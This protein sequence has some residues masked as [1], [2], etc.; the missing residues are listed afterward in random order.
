MTADDVKQLIESQIAGRWNETNL[1]GIELRTSLIQRIKLIHRRVIGG[2][3]ADEVI[4]AWLVLEEDKEN[5]E[6]YKIIY[7]ESNG[8]FGLASKGIPDRQTFCACRILR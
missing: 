3:S 4:E 5:Q 2:R 8:M 1:H 6:G 7:N